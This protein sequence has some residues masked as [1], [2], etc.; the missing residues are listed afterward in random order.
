MIVYFHRHPITND[1]F[2]VGIG[3][4]KSRAYIF[5][6]KGRNQY[7]HNYVKKHGIPVVEIVHEPAT[8]K[9]AVELELKYIAQFGRKCDGSGCL[10]NLTIGG[11]GG[12]LGHIQSDE[13]KEKISVKNTGKIRSEAA[14]KNYK[15]AQSRPEVI[16]KHKVYK[17][18]DEFKENQRRLRLGKSQSEETKQKRSSTLKGHA[19]SEETKRKISLKNTGKVRSAETR[20]LMGDIQ[21]GKKRTPEAIANKVAAT[22]KL[23]LNT[24][25]GI[26]YHGLQEAAESLPM[27]LNT[28]RSKMA[29]FTKNTTPFIYA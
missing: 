21:R 3:K 23:V 26:Y 18:S 10:V 12:A 11:D 28:L 17:S 13:H 16:A 19:V 29:G 9:E 20:K 4:K 25:T 24:L 15:D 7:W 14:K 22:K 5:T 1:V 6:K 2:Y 27:N 8:R